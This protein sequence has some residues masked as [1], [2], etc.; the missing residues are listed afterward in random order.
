M[1]SSFLLIT[2]LPKTKPQE[3]KQRTVLV[4]VEG[5]VWTGS[6]IFVLQACHTVHDVPITWTSVYRY[7]FLGYT[8]RKYQTYI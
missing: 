4:T 8:E 5:S 6:G 7:R 1:E 3:M 2:G